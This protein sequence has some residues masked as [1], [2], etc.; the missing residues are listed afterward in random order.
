[1]TIED[2]R[3]KEENSPMLKLAYEQSIIQ[4]E[5]QQVG[6][7]YSLDVSSGSICPKCSQL[8]LG[9]SNCFNCNKETN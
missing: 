6:I 2:F 8:I 5:I 3:V 4:A 9:N 1:M 7:N